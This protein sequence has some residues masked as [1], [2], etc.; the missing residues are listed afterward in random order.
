MGEEVRSAQE[1]E[2]LSWRLRGWGG[3]QVTRHGEG[4]MDRGRWRGKGRDVGVRGWEPGPRGTGR[5][6]GS[7]HVESG[8]V[9]GPEGKESRGAWRGRRFWA[10]EGF[11]Q[12]APT[13]LPDLG[14]CDDGR[15]G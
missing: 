10:A 2:C 3:R 1:A 5:S 13:G 14:L 7:G 8:G 11:A 15:T 9:D 6:H 12:T 4:V